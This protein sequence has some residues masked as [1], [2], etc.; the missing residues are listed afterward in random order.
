MHHLYRPLFVALLVVAAVPASA[1]WSTQSP[2]PTGQE[3]RG[4]AAPTAQRAFVVGTDNAFDDQGAL[5]ETADGGQT[6]IPRDVP[7][8][9]SEPLNGIFF[10]DSQHGWTYGNANYRTTDGGSTWDELPFLGSTYRMEFWTPTFG[11]ASTNDGWVSR[12]GGLTWEP[13]PNGMVDFAFAD[14]G[15][16]LLGLGVSTSGIYR[17][18]DGGLTFTLALGGSAADVVFLTPTLAVGI[19]DDAFVRSTDGGTTWTTGAAAEGRRQL[20]AVSPTVALAWGRSGSFPDYDDRLFRSGDGGQT[21]ADLGEVIDEETV[22]VAVA[23]PQTVV[24][25]DRGGDVLHSAD[26]GQTW[27]EAYDSPGPWPGYFGTV[28][29]AFADA[30]TGYLAFG[31]GLVL[32]TTDGGAS[33]RQVGSGYGADLAALDRF[34]DGR[35]LAVG[36][37]GALLTNAGAAD[38]AWLLQPSPTT[39]DL[40]GVDVVGPQDVV[41]VDEGGRVYRSA[42]GGDTWT[43][44][45]ATPPSFDAEDLDFATPLD[46]WVA[47]FGSSGG[48]VF[49]TTDGGASWTAAPGFSGAYVAVDFEGQSGWALNVT[50]RYYRTTDGGATWVQGELPDASGQVQ[51]LDFFDAA[52]GYA[53]GWYGFAA[54]SDDGGATWE[55]LPIPNGDDRLTDLYLLGPNELW[56]STTDDVA[57]YSATGGQTWARIE[58]GSGGFGNFSAI[59]AT[60]DG[61]AWTAGSQGVIERFAGPPP[62]PL[63][64]PPEASFEFDTVRLTVHLTDT[65]ADPDGTL[66][67]WLWDFGDGATSTEQNPSHTYVEA[68]T[69]IVRLTVTDD[70]GDTGSTVRF[71]TVQP[72]PGGT[73]GD[74]TEVTPFESPFVTPQDEDFWVVATAPADYDGDGDVDIAVL[75]Y[76]VVYHQSA[77]DQLL[78]LRNDGEGAPDEWAFTYVEVDLGDLSAGASDLAWADLDGYGDQDLV[79][80]TDGETVVY[81]NR[82]GVLVL[83]DTDL[84]GYYEDNDQADFDLRSI[85]AADYDND[86]DQDLLLPSV[87]D[88]DTFEYR[89]ALLR[90]DGPNGSGGWLFTEADATFAPTR[91]AQSAW[92]D[93]DGDEDLDLLLVHLAPLTD[94]GFIRRYRNDGGGVFVGEDL[95]G[96][97]TVEHGEAQWGDYDADGDLDILIA[98][99]VKETDGTFNQVLRVYRNDGGGVYAEETLIDAP[100]ADWIDL[101]AGTWADY[102]SDGDV[103]ILL[104]GT[105][106]SGSQID[107][108]AEIYANSGGTF[109]DT[110]NDL[111]APRSSGTRGGAFSWLDVDGEGD[112]DYFIAGSYFVPGGNGLVEAQMHLYR[113][114]VPVLNLRPSA[115]TG[116][117]AEVLG[118]EAGGGAAVTLAWDPSTDDHTPSVALTYDLDL[119]RDGVPLETPSRLPQ[120][121]NVSAVTAWLL[122]GLEAGTYT[123]TLRAVDSAYNGSLRSEGTFTVGDAPAYSLSAS[124]TTPLTVAPGGEV[125]FQYA[126]TNHTAAPA[127]GD[128]YFVA[129]RGGTPVASGTVRSGTLPGGKTVAGTYTQRVPASVPAGTY[130][131]RLVIGRFPDVAVAEAAFEI[132]VQTHTDGPAVR[133]TSPSSTASRRAPART[134]DAARTADAAWPV[135]DAGPW[136]VVVVLAVSDRGGST[137]AASDAPDAS[138]TSLPEVADLSAIYPNPV[139]RAAT[140]RFGL[141]AAADVDLAVYDLLGR[142]VVQLAREAFP[143][144]LHE[145][146][147]DAAGLAGGTYLVRFSTEGA[148]VTRRVVLMR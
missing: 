135:E 30:Q 82:D 48:A 127:A 73:F 137:E 60:A 51:D 21:W 134:S 105:Y 11:F 25:L 114:D 58:I 141:P 53:V 42:D 140:I 142:R 101:H 67:A 87:F 20:V 91:H 1:Q 62:P 76:Y 63:N 147:W 98:G 125:G 131:Y 40:R 16:G 14:D 117:T 9:L 124:N 129:E 28:V 49:H 6:W 52:T 72:G 29:P 70:D 44:G 57:Y 75:G 54:R 102:D 74:F 5:F 83:T 2:V 68:D 33:W 90:N 84:P 80:G 123:W 79:V 120:P 32:K 23:D 13:S 7:F 50:G 71:I 121:G 66:T 85:T 86:G 10:L 81:R 133:G 89:T 36:A 12:D 138:S 38:A 130:T 139:R 144:G 118:T 93:F 17:T 146:R 106:N 116:L 113:N 3:L 64:R 65:S 39:L 24:A 92:A 132:V 4:V 122:T 119:Y 99:R 110:E 45:A 31:R 34:S 27:A 112:L 126:V 43:A 15:T 69:Y 108:K 95:L 109:V 18:L 88:F 111:P 107:G 96:S 148:T 97:L 46:G 104:A 128:L 19:V 61:D 78:L 145:V 22:S 55:T 103:D 35:L 94:D 8:S 37:G 26:A 100:N 59:V 41:V 143:A 136:A 56:V 47:G 77:E 115:P